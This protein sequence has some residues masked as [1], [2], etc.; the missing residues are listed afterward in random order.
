VLIYLKVLVFFL[1]SGG[2]NDNDHGQ[3]FGDP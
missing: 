1:L 2:R 3:K